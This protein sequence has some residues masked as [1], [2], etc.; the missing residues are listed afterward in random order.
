M[1]Y[2]K[3]IKLFESSL[4]AILGGK[5]IIIEI[6]FLLFSIIVRNV[7]ISHFVVALTVYSILLRYLVSDKDYD[8]NS[9]H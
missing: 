5:I 4:G 3:Y 1:E 8:P 6:F 7:L 2:I 9:Q